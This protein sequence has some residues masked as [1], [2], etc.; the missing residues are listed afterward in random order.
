MELV[1]Y[2]ASHEPMGPINVGKVFF[3]FQIQEKILFATKSNFRFFVIFVY[4]LFCK[5][6][7]R[8]FLNTFFYFFWLFLPL[9]KCLDI[10][11]KYLI[12]QVDCR[13]CLIFWIWKA[14]NSFCY[15]FGFRIKCYKSWKAVFVYK[16]Q[17]NFFLSWISLF[18]HWPMGNCYY[19][20][21]YFCL[22]PI[23]TSPNT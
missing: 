23:T 16:L 20:M 21:E 6:L 1:I 2:G 18:F 3:F 9:T 10:F 15:S 11:K 14:I 5:K 17:D 8:I 19:R 4:F 22:M 13:F 12:T 7:V